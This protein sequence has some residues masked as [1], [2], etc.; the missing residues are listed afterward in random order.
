MKALI[1]RLDRR[2]DPSRGRQ[3][4]V[5]LIIKALEAEAHPTFFSETC[6][7]AGGGI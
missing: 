5:V 2:L 1:S 4:D 6:G 3:I 7:H